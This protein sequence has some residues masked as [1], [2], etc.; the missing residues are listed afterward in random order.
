VQSFATGEYPH[1]TYT[2][3]N[4]HSVGL[5][6][7]KSN[8]SSVRI[9]SLNLEEKM[10]AVA[11]YYLPLVLVL[12]PTLVHGR[13][14]YLGC[15]DL[16]AAGWQVGSTS[17]W[18]ATGGGVCTVLTPIIPPCASLSRTLSHTIY[19]S[20]QPTP[21]PMLLVRSTPTAIAATADSP[22][23]YFLSCLDPMGGNSRTLS[24]GS[25]GNECAITGIPTTYALNTKYTL[26]VSN[27]T[28]PP[29]LLPFCC[30]PL[31]LM[32]V[33]VGLAG[34]IDRVRTTAHPHP[35][36]TC[37]AHGAASTRFGLVFRSNALGFQAGG[38]APTC[39]PSQEE[40]LGMVGTATPGFVAT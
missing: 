12:L 7:E 35:C 4:L 36:L 31:C 6:S 18:Q 20:R 33:A 14:G 32:L 29:F 10:K 34:E 24:D 40:P 17:K 11:D 19:V 13:P 27:R 3:T 30:P 2:N 16:N 1:P 8:F 21:A 38:D 26:K 39:S 15:E 28:R 9:S 23:I 37:P 5:S 22:V 25:G